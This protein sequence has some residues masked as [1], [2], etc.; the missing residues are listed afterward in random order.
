MVFTNIPG[1]PG[2]KVSLI[3]SS[4]MYFATYSRCDFAL[5]FLHSEFRPTFFVSQRSSKGTSMNELRRT[6]VPLLS[7]ENNTLESSRGA[8]HTFRE[9][10]KLPLLSSS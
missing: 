3:N 10:L 1:V 6:R 5:S 7:S 9:L 4:R 8:K 2:G